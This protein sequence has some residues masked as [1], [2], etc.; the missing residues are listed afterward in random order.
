MWDYKLADFDGLCTAVLEYDWEQVF[1][2]ADVN[3]I[4]DSWSAKLL[5]LTKQFIPT[6]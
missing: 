1:N 6:C 3:D 5:E 4:C 2:V